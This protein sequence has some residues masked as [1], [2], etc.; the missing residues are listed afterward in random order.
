[1]P[2]PFA[3]AWLPPSG[4]YAGRVRAVYPFFARFQ[5]EVRQRAY[6]LYQSL[7]SYGAGSFHREIQRGGSAFSIC[8]IGAVLLVDRGDDATNSDLLAV[9]DDMMDDPEA[10]EFRTEYDDGLVRNLAEAMGVQ[11]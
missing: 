11:A 1:M 5:P 7:P 8:P 4:G 9:G 6:D 3:W 10:A 2:P